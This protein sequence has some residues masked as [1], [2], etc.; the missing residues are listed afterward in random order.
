MAQKTKIGK[1]STPTNAN[2]EYIPPQ[3]ITP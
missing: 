2:L 3:A 1:N